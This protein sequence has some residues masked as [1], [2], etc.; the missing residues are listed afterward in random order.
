MICSI[1][2][3][4]GGGGGSGQTLCSER[5]ELQRAERADAS[6]ANE[7]SRKPAVVRGSPC[8]P[9]LMIQQLDPDPDHV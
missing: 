6:E 2:W 3:L 9:R 7:S 1:L 5:S 8:R 4:K